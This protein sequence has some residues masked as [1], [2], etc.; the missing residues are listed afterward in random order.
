MSGGRFDYNQNLIR[1]IAEDLETIVEHNDCTREQLHNELGDGFGN[2]RD[3]CIDWQNPDDPYWYGGLFKWYD[4]CKTR[5]EVEAH[6][7]EKVFGYPKEVIDRFA[8]AVVVLKMAYAYVQRID[9]FLSGDD[10]EE[11]FLK[12]LKSELSAIRGKPK[13]PKTK[14]GENG[15]V[16][17]E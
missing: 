16:K 10:C 5:E 3:F 4:G 7:Q 11:S 15:G 12:R 1:D 2:F 8:E 17:G 14:G 13:F 6:N 9:W